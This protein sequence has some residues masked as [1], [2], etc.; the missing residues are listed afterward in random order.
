[1]VESAAVDVS[2]GVWS[3]AVKEE[4]LLCTGSRC[5]DDTLNL[6]FGKLAIGPVHVSV[7]DRL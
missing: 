6:V 3:A 1:M 7:P 2:R 5:D 4:F